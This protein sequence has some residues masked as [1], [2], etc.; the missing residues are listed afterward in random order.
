LT[1]VSS[2]RPSRFDLI[3]QIGMPSAAARRAYLAA[4][5]P[6]LDGDTLRIWVERS[7]GFSISRHLREM[8]VLCRC[9]GKPLDEGHRPAGR[10]AAGL[11]ELVPTPTTAARSVV[12]FASRKLA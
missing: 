6:S 7:E 4:K 9:Y 5:E 1:A 3:K 10:D 11:A 8:I 2:D 12:G